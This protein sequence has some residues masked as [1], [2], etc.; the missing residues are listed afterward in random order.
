MYHHVIAEFLGTA[1]MIVFGIGVHSNETLNETKH[2][3]FSHMFAITAWAFGIT[4]TLYLFNGAFINPSMTL[5]QAVLGNISWNKV[6]PYIIAQIAG[7]FVGAILIYICY[8]D[9]FKISEDKI[10]SVKIRNIFCTSPGIQNLPR[11]FFVEFFATFIF[12]SCILG[13]TRLKNPVVEPIA[14]GLLVW[15]IGMGL[16]GLTGFA[17]NLARDMGPRI[18]YAILPIKNKTEADWKYGILVPGIA[19]LLGGVCAALFMQSF[20]GM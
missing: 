20:F 13:I 14:V 10:D 6:I 17:M 4:V 3:G 15:A 9:H 1:L 12:I 7:G 8:A 16:G 11:K 2:H 19:P 5:A 18:A